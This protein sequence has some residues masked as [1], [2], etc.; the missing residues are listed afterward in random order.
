MIVL[1][2]SSWKKN[3]KSVIEWTSK[4]FSYFPLHMRPFGGRQPMCL[5]KCWKKHEIKK[6]AL[7]NAVSKSHCDINRMNH[8]RICVFW[9]RVDSSVHIAAMQA[10]PVQFGHAHFI[11]SISFILSFICGFFSS[12]KQCKLYNMN[13]ENKFVSIKFRIEENVFTRHHFLNVS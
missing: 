5:L 11:V 6:I 7:E 4:R 8:L 3:V 10:L 13:V 2:G 9:M 1:F 12:V